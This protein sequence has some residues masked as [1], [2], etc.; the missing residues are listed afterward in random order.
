MS[1]RQSMAWRAL[2]AISL[3]WRCRAG[4]Q[5]S[6]QLLTRAPTGQINY[7]EFVNM[8]MSK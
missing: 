8:M 5:H 1:K 6:Q 4:E 2:C 3:G 7:A